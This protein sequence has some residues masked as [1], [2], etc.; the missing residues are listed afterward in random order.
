MG[1]LA[2]CYLVSE[3]IF[4]NLA[5]WLVSNL[6]S[7][8]LSREARWPVVFEIA[9]SM[10]K[11]RRNYGV[12]GEILEGSDPWVAIQIPVKNILCIKTHIFNY[13]LFNLLAT[14]HRLK[15]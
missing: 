13:Q 4:T 12:F 10:I 11:K 15:C 2:A 6:F 14:N 9:L 3:K 1:S 5:G 7:G 8:D